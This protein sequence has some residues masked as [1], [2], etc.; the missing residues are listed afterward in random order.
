MRV[1]Y[2]AYHYYA[3]QTSYAVYVTKCIKHK[4]LI[5]FHVARIH[6]YLKVIIASSVVALRHL[7]KPLHSVHK[8]LNQVVCVLLEPYVTQHN[9]VVAKFV[10][11]NHSR[12]TRN[13]AFAPQALLA[14]KNWCWREIDLGGH[15]FHGE[16]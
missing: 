6:F 12:V 4:I 8:L 1:L 10:I 13:L 3:V 15:F 11:V 9:H 7:L 5:I 14:F 16:S 2:L